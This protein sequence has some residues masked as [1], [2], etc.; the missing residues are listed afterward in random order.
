[1]LPLTVSVSTERMSF[2]DSGM[3]ETIL[4]KRIS[5]GD[6]RSF[7][8][9]Y[10]RFSRVL[11]ATAYSVLHN[12]ELSEDVV[13]EVFIQIWQKASLFNPGK[14]K[15][16]TWAMTLTRNRAIDRMRSI[17]RRGHLME[18]LLEAESVEEQLDKKDS[19][20]SAVLGETS[21]LLQ[22]ALAKLPASQRIAIEMTF[23]SSLSMREVSEKLG[24]PLGTVKA[25]VR[26]G[27]M[28]LRDLLPNDLSLG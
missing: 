2:E 10:D 27:L 13:Q 26:R 28:R 4:L 24:E 3:Q 14:G 19:L 17:Q 23:I 6:R 22:E 21:V 5:E 8:D 9:L 11:F 18:E 15:P 1:M 20:T 7:S 16:L 25:R 12:R